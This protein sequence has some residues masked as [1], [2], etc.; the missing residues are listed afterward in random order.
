MQS[1]CWLNPVDDAC[2]MS[3]SERLSHGQVDMHW[4]HVTTTLQ[5][6]HVNAPSTHASHGRSN[7][8]ETTCQDLLLLLDAIY[9]GM[10]FLVE[11]YV[12]TGAEKALSPSGLLQQ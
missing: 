5:G 8:Q 7:T 4:P 2:T 11:V 6:S 9:I 10:A 12:L 1:S 3:S